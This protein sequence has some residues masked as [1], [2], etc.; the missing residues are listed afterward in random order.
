MTLEKK[1]ALLFFLS[2]LMKENYRIND[3]RSSNFVVTN[4]LRTIAQA[5]AQLTFT[6]LVISLEIWYYFLGL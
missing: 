2:K 4:N 6:D 1:S 3:E 5:S